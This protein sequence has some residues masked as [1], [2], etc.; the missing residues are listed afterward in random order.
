MNET[1]RDHYTTILEE[2]D[3]D[4]QDALTAAKRKW[5]QRKKERSREQMERKQREEKECLVM[6][7]EEKT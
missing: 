4:M 3:L 1:E 7:A 2:Y 6:A 5:N